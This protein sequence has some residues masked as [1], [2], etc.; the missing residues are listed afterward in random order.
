MQAV[1]IF[2]EISKA[3]LLIDNNWRVKQN[4]KYDARTAHI[5]HCN[6]VHDLNRFASDKGLDSSEISY[7]IH[8]WRNFKRHEAWLLLICETV[9]GVTL[10]IDKFHKHQDFYLNT[11]GEEHP[12]D[13]KVTRL[14]SSVESSISD[15]E[16]AYWMYLNQ[17]RQGRFHLKNRFFIIGQPESA[18]YNIEIARETLQTFCGQ[19]SKYRHF[20]YH[21]DGGKSRAVVLRQ[22]LK[23]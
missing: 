8:R 5:Y 18:L 17:S 11:D 9:P 1:E 12:F 21:S 4:D 10:T 2:E 19:M 7:S 15:L 23:D 6:T 16:L 20:I 13:L 14:P 3:D 22:I